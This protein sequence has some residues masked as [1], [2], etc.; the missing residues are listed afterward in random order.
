MEA[1]L[2]LG[3]EEGG[4]VV[5][6][7]LSSSG[8]RRTIVVYGLVFFGV[9]G[10]VVVTCVGVCVGRGGVDS[11]SSG[12]GFFFKVGGCYEDGATEFADVN[13]AEGGVLFD[14]EPEV[15]IYLSVLLEMEKGRETVDGALVV[16]HV[17]VETVQVDGG[18]C[19]G[20]DDFRER[21]E[22][23]GCGGCHLQM[24]MREKMGRM[25][26]MGDGEGGLVLGCPV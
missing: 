20:G 9:V 17:D 14:V 24:R 6:A 22:T 19:L 21:R 25:M 12:G 18:T 10:V 15:E 26:E 16:A 11:S 3:A 13:A 8:V 1:K 2:G 7:N 5:V 23:G 4:N